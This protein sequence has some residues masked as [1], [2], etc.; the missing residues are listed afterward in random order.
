MPGISKLVVKCFI[1]FL[2]LVWDFRF[3]NT[4]LSSVGMSTPILT[5]M[6]YW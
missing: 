2:E 1:H 4:S 6:S 3:S 5:S